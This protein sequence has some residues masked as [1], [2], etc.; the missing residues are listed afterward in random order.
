MPQGSAFLRYCAVG[1]LATAL[2]YA[3]LIAGVEQ[4]GLS[5]PAA[6]A[7][8]AVAGALLAYACNRR[9][10]FASSALHRQA[11]PRFVAV[12]LAGAAVHAAVVGGLTLH[13]GWHY[14]SAQGI[15]T[16]LMLCIGFALNRAWTFA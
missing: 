13:A 15:A 9:Y 11:L 6:S 8:G 2:H 4:A 7:L 16:L 12:A 14:L 5:A 10:T 1:G 3:L